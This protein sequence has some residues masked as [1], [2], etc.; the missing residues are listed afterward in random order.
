MENTQPKLPKTQV[1]AEMLL[2]HTKDPWKSSWPG[3]GTPFGGDTFLPHI[4]TV[5]GRYGVASKVYS[6]GD[7][8]LVDSRENAELMRNELAIQE[9][10]EARMKSTALLSWHVSPMDDG[11]D[12]RTKQRLQISGVNQGSRWDAEDLAAKVSL[13]LQ[14]TPNLTKLFYSLMEA[15]WYGR[16]GAELFWRPRTVQGLGRKTMCITH[17]QPRHGDKLVFRY[18][19]GTY[20]Y[21]P[22]QVGIRIGPG[23][24]VQREFTDYAGN[25][26]KKVEA[27]QY[28]LAY[29]LDKAERE[30]MIIHRHLIEDG[31]FNHPIK[32]GS[33]H[34]I[35]IRSRIYW[36]WY[37]YSECLKLLLEYIERSALGIEIWRYPAHNKEAQT[38][39]KEAAQ[40]RGAPGRSI[41][42]VPI[43]EGENADL[44][45]VQIVEPG[46]Q[47]ADVLQNVLDRFF[48]HKIKRYILGQTLTTEADATGI[49][50]GVAAA[51]QATYADIVRFD[52]LGLAETITQDVIRTI[53]LHN[54]PGSEGI[55]LKFNF[56]T[57]SPEM[58]FKL[59][60]YRQAWEMG[61]EIKT[62]DVFKV[63]GAARPHEDDDKL[64]NPIFAQQQM[65]DM[66]QMAAQEQM[67]MEADPAGSQEMMAPVQEPAMFSATPIISAE[68]RDSIE[69]YNQEN[70]SDAQI[71]AGNYKKTK[72]SW[73]GM[74]ISIEAPK[75]STRRG[76]WGEKVM[77]ND[78]GY[79]RGTTGADGDHVDCF[80]GDN[81]DSEIVFVIDQSK[82]GRNKSFDEHKV[83]I[84]CENKKQAKDLYLN[85]FHSGWKC[86]EISSFTVDQFK[87]WLN[88]GCQK[89]PAAK[90][91][92]K[93]SAEQVEA[94]REKY[95]EQATI[96][97]YG[98]DP[99]S[100]L[101][102]PA[103][104]AEEHRKRGIERKPQA[105]KMSNAE[106][107]AKV[108]GVD[109]TDESVHPDP[110]EYDKQRFDSQAELWNEE[111]HPR[112]TTEHDDSHGHKKPGE[113]APKESPVVTR[114]DW[115]YATND[116]SEKKV[117]GHDKT[118]HSAFFTGVDDVGHQGDPAWMDYPKENEVKKESQAFAIFQARK[119]MAMQ[120]HTPEEDRPSPEEWKNWIKKTAA[121]VDMQKRIEN[122]PHADLY[123]ERSLNYSGGEN[124]DVVSVEF[125]H[126][127]VYTPLADAISW[128]KNKKS[129]GKILGVAP[130]PDTDNRADDFRQGRIN[131]S[132]SS[133]YQRQLTRNELKL[134]VG[135]QLVKK[136]QH[137]RWGRGKNFNKLAGIPEAQMT[138]RQKMQFAKA[139]S[140]FQHD[141]TRED[142]AK[143]ERLGVTPKEFH[144]AVKWGNVDL[145]KSIARQDKQRIQFRRSGRAVLPPDFEFT[146]D[147]SGNKF[148]F[149]AENANQPLR[150]STGVSVCKKTGR[151]QKFQYSSQ[152]QFNWNEDDHPRE[153]SSHDG[154]KPGE[155]AP[156]NQG[157]QS[158]EM[159]KMFLHPDNPE[160]LSEWKQKPSGIISPVFDGS[161]V[162]HDHEHK[163]LVKSHNNKITLIGCGATKGESKS[164]AADMYQ[165]GYYHMNK[166][167][168]ENSG[169]PW[170]ILSA[171]HG[172][173]DPEEWI[174]PY[175]HRLKKSEVSEWAEDTVY[176]LLEHLDETLEMDTESGLE[177]EI[178]AGSTYANALQNEIEKQ[179]L[180]DFGITVTQP[181]KGMGIGKRQGWLKR[182]GELRSEAK[183]RKADIETLKN[184][185][186][187]TARGK[188]IAGR[189]AEMS[190]DEFRQ[191]LDKFWYSRPVHFKTEEQQ[192]K[193]D[194]MDLLYTN[195]QNRRF[196]EKEKSL[197][198]ITVEEQSEAIELARDLISGEATNMPK[199]TPD[200]A[201]KYV[202]DI[203]V[204]PEDWL[205]S[206]L[207]YSAQSHSKDDISIANATSRSGGA[208]GGHPV[209]LKHV[210]KI[211]SPGMKIL[212][213]GAGRQA[214]QAQELKAE[215]LDVTAYDFGGNV[216]EGLHDTDALNREY[217]LVYASNVLNVQSTAEDL[218]ST[219]KEIAASVKP[220]GTFVG[221]LPDS[222]RKGAFDGL[223]PLA[224][225][226]MVQK[227]LQKY[228]GQ[229]E[230]KEGNSHPVF[231]ATKTQTQ[232]FSAM[233]DEQYSASMPTRSSKTGVG[234]QI[235]NAVYVHRKYTGSIPESERV[236]QAC[237]GNENWDWDIAKI[238]PEQI[239]L[240]KSPD[241]DAAEEPISGD[242][243]VVRQD[244]SSKLV[245]QLDDPNIYH[246][247]WLMVGD[248]YG[249][250]DV[251][252]SKNRSKSWI[253]LPV[254]KSK[255][256]KKSYWEGNVIPLIQKFGAQ[257][258]CDPNM[259]K[260]GKTTCKVTQIESYSADQ[261]S[262]FV[263][264]EI[265]RWN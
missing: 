149:S 85:N 153:T 222:P 101:N 181:M 229:V 6:Y 5:A 212:D 121:M 206:R 106:R 43:P 196:P 195:E 119:I 258:D 16:Q 64:Q 186:A 116:D 55:W 99:Y 71:E 138:D 21:D 152:N 225:A 177:I 59:D 178:L 235:G 123:K 163:Q 11:L 140:S 263:E 115:D 170:G 117:E 239:S 113:F 183:S 171:K 216:T 151:S 240:I 42:M 193:Y 27:T 146:T 13:I 66:A 190:D 158:P 20:E 167:Y 129:W 75:G 10:L 60:A 102:L 204:I 230:K 56:D 211:V 14:R 87:K 110:H 40:R 261:I 233:P 47:G 88:E 249:G 74:R 208:V 162:Q 194:A 50:S 44:Y 80:I 141:L 127:I 2:R 241:F 201:V 31:D 32:A 49:G 111:D 95:G 98:Y 188:A 92:G 9:C 26:H 142:K 131:K 148:L 24:N 3:G 83:V 109:Y 136:A 8:A 70:A 137:S 203:F 132:S 174:E 197:D 168:A 134:A 250:F 145:V 244:G 179:N 41:L 256:G 251:E 81:L 130:A 76:K 176:R 144:N 173:L 58:Q 160:E 91:V 28:G 255:I 57:E 100:E 30:K 254:D 259:K 17:W 107:M 94:F 172:F 165:S 52:S 139:K 124:E 22:N 90:H 205:K 93:Y 126:Q 36:T 157:N 237:K 213:F 33:I 78:Y 29:F 51:H 69:R 97:R 82:M 245:S 184:T 253:N 108:L 156:K 252:Q 224:G 147:K 77:N 262:S 128:A 180:G 143:L 169:N 35:G 161:P 175:E 72:F 232:K 104:I 105:P 189:L 84:G 192:A 135:N 214:V 220:N 223:T 219:V 226:E 264:S 182:Q 238:T 73:N 86:G 46:L 227:L 155:F 191:K 7:E 18:D 103:D 210:K 34:G 257:G 65:M 37:A 150:Y 248:D 125:E 4:F 164:S 187:S 185:F 62:D 15:I 247:K 54:F 45:D 209:T 68:P 114:S 234:K 23:Y 61:A 265:E 53:Q 231:F 38:K 200:E 19:D 67:P 166:T 207:Q 1:P 89:T 96:A 112:E 122:S 199:H 217:D 260:D 48:G 221:N 236:K 218:E 154:K 118:D 12:E 228:I 198:N 79:I 202:S 215:G 63:L 120:Q 25:K 242:S 246:H 39:T 159:Q 243:L 133:I